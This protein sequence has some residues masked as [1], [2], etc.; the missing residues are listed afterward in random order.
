MRIGLDD[1]LLRFPNGA[2]SGDGME[3]SG[4]PLIATMHRAKSALGSNL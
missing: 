2:W 1:A 3:S 4:F